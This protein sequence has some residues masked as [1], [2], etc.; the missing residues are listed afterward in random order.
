M[1]IVTG[2]RGTPHITSNAVQAFNQGIFGSGEYILEVGNKFD[3]TIVDAN[4]ITLEDGEGVLQ[5]V[6]FRIEPGTTESVNIQNGTLGYNRNDL[7]CARYSKNVITG[8]E[9]VDLVVIEGAPSESDASDPSYNTGDLLNG[10]TPIDFPLWRVSLSGL[11]PSLTS[12]TSSNTVAPAKMN[13]KLYDLPFTVGMYNNNSR[14]IIDPSA[15]LMFYCVSLD[16]PANTA[17]T[18]SSI[19][20][21]MPVI[22]GAQEVGQAIYNPVI[23]YEY[24]NLSNYSYGF[25]RVY[26]SAGSSTATLYLT[27][28][29]VRRYVKGVIVMPY[30]DYYSLHPF[31]DATP[32][33]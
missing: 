28:A 4:T 13:G 10:D 31:E 3:A 8:V 18:G 15:S 6:H 11:T 33:N 2:Y 16:V 9:S 21:Q 26:S 23:A 1:N 27:S 20:L 12:M 25:V 5:G 29:N 7:I 17:A 14:L 32:I 30:T 22:C 24:N 19:A